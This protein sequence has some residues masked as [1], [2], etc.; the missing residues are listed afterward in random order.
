MKPVQFLTILTLI[1]G[2][3]TAL[4]S[5]Q[6]IDLLIQNKKYDEALLQINLQIGQNATADLFYKKGLI[7]NSLQNYQ[8]AVMAFSEALKLQPDNPDIL[9]EMADGLSALGNYHDAN[10]YFQ[11]SAKLQPENLLLA[12][13]LGRNY[14]SL[15]DFKQAYNCFSDIY[16]LD[17]INV[18]W[19]KQLAFCAF[20]TGKKSQAITL[21]KKVLQQKST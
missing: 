18:Y 11:K 21:Y 14:I 12:A 15:K 4:F 3:S 20:K 2:N 8:E 13:K 19:N 1:F 16:T 10:S 7:N 9:S 5:Q 6:E 17:S